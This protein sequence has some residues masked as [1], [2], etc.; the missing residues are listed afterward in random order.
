MLC[1]AGMLPLLRP[2][3]VVEHRSTDDIST[4]PRNAVA[5]KGCSQHQLHE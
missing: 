5:V 4:G 1:A 3:A 2:A